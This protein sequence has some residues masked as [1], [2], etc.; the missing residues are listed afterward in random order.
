M[1]LGIIGLPQ[2]G[3]KTVFRLLTG[4]EAAKAPSR[5]G[6]RYGT[7]P[8]RDPR[9][10]ALNAMYHPRRMR[11]AEFNIALPPDIEPDSSRS[12]EWLAPLRNVDAY[13]HVVRV[14][15]SPSVFHVRGSVEPRR[16]L[17]LVDTELLLADLDLVE[18][19]LNRIQREPRTGDH[20]QQRETAVLERCRGHLEDE[21]S[22]RTLDLSAEERDSIVHLQFLT[23]KPQVVVFNIGDDSAAGMAAC[24]ELAAAVEADGATVVVLSADIE[25]DM[26]EL[27]P[28]ERAEFM[29]DLDLTEPAAHR[30]SRAAFDCLGLISFFTVGEDEVRA[31]PIRQGMTAQRAAGKIHSDIERGFI[32]AE[33]IAQ[34]DLIR[35]G[36]EK[37]AKDANLYRLNGKDYVVRDGDIINF[38]FNV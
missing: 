9:V 5:A 10:D 23:L 17:N 11:Y 37:A 18:K 20:R 33:T 38:R 14:F 4:L 28:E 8:V 34:P 2:V 35:A 21:R 36:S 15:E 19:R 16:D 27:E 7:A 12:A 29:A 1:E 25:A 6:I 30:L 32:R 13:L 22:L 26:L 24:R 31:W 3:K